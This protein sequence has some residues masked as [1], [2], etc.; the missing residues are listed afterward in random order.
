MFKPSK[1]LHIFLLLSTLSLTACPKKNTPSTTSTTSSTSS[2]TTITSIISFETYGGSVIE[3]IEAP[4]GSYIQ[5]P[6]DPLR[7]DSLF[8]AWYKDYRFLNIVSWPYLVGS[9]TTLHAKYEAVTSTNDLNYVYDGTTESYSVISTINTSL[10]NIVIAPKVLREADNKYYP[11]TGIGV[12][13]FA[14]S[15]VETIT[16]PSSVTDIAIGA[17]FN[18]NHLVSII[19]AEDN[20]SYLGIN[21]ILYSRDRHILHTVPSNYPYS[22]L[23]I[24]PL[25][26]TISTFAFANNSNIESISFPEGL[27][28]INR[29]AFYS[30]SSIK[31]LTLKE[32]YT[33][34][35]HAFTNCPFLV[36]FTASSNK[37]ASWDVSFIEN[38][39]VIYYGI[40][41]PTVHVYYTTFEYIVNNDQVILV[42]YISNNSTNISIPYQI[43]DYPVT[44]IGYRLFNLNNITISSVS[45]PDSITRICALAFRYSAINS[46]NIPVNVTTIDE[47]AFYGTP[48]L[49]QFVLDSSNSH[50]AIY[51]EGLYT[52][53]YKTLIAFPSSNLITTHT[54]QNITTRIY[55][56]AFSNTKYLRNLYLPA[57]VNI[58]PYA[59]YNVPYLSVTTDAVENVW[60]SGFCDFYP[61]LANYYAESNKPTIT[62]A[63]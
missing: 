58:N 62:F 59:L 27:T 3:S 5:K 2:N 18:A 17:F 14:S 15:Y 51:Q 1:L 56:Y 35:D 48:A 24:N 39:T 53:D 41:D 25:T 47:L 7:D 19:V 26:T 8:L 11:V 22:E 46:I 60:G 29:Y 44:T 32:E 45:L 40:E 49:T 50:F 33:I 63:S 20:S 12:T 43:A 9:S 37:P 61:T 21:G 54:V 52:I 13:A 10:T 42:R 6:A 30:L 4:I 28:T 34:Y 23:T 57:S 55:S 38:D 16:I 36:L 31:Y